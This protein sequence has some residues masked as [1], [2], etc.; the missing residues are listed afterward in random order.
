MKHLRIL[1]PVMRR[2]EI[3][4]GRRELRTA[5]RDC[6]GLFASVA[7]FGVFA[8]LLMLTGPLYMLQVYDRVLSSRSVETLLALSILVLFF[9]AIMGLLEYARGRILSRIGARFLE[10]MSGRVFAAVL[11]KKTIA[12]DAE[13]AKSGLRDLEAIQNVLSSQTLIAVFDLPWVPVFLLMIFVFHPALG[14]LALGGGLTLIGLTLLNQWIT[15]RAQVQATTQRQDANRFGDDILAEAEL[16]RAMGMQDA[17]FAKWYKLQRAS[18]SLDLMRTDRTASISAI[19]KSSRLVLQS[20]MLGLGALM[21]LRD[22][23]TPGAMIAASILFGRTMA[24]LDLALSQ[25]GLVQRAQ[26]GWSNLAVLLSDIPEPTDRTALPKPTA[27]LSCTQLTVVPP[28]ARSATLRMLSFDLPPGQAL[29]VIGPSGAGKST[30]A[31]ALTGV[32]SPAGGSVR[33]GGATLDQYGDRSLGQHIGYLPQ[34]VTMFD[35]TIGENI[36]GLDPNVDADAIVAAAQ[37]AAAHDLILRQPDGYDTPFAV[38]KGRLSGGELQRIG[39]ARALFGDPVLLVLDEPNSNLDAEGTE[40]LNK[41]VKRT[42]AAGSSV[43]IMA[44]RPSAIQECELLLVIE[45]GLRR[46]FGARD[47]VLRDAVLNHERITKRTRSGGVA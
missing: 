31:R 4:N 47:Q 16:I 25:W 37:S 28:E 12:P 13:E 20:A 36:A 19:T 35:G 21:V 18:L 9:Y 32:W 41:A 33:L 27:H 34:K 6:M 17:S 40:A 42:K 15:K 38:A 2:A 5:Y 46:A 29:G 7:I 44:H 10:R 30:L 24:P 8:N 3:A 43:I 11:R 45:N 39:L 14:Y 23:M 22:Q 1:K 26:M